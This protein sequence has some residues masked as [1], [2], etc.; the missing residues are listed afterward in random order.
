MSA[1][2]LQ[3]YA[4]LNPMVVP[5]TVEQY[6]RMIQAGI[7]PEGA[8]IELLDGFLVRKDRG[9]RGDSPMTVGYWHAWVVNRVA[10]RAAR[11]HEL[12]GLLQIQQ[13]I[14]AGPDS[15][16]EPDASI[17]FGRLDELRGRL[18]LAVEVSC[19]IEVAES[20]LRFDRTTK[21]RIYAN[22]GIPQY[23]IVN[24]PDRLVEEYTQP[25][26]GSGRYD[27]ARRIRPGQTVQLRV[28]TESL[29]VAVAEL[30]P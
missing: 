18:P 13:P 15:E 22:A 21:Q 2:T 29:E 28:G 23:V 6:H 30:F 10:L 26:A 25:V 5:I 16:P 11:V 12:G 19:V 1:A 4:E 27:Q 9:R 14:S 17:V 3:E 24:L 7:L 8:P 20:S